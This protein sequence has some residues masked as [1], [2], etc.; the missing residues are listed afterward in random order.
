MHIRMQQWLSSN[1]A[2]LFL[3]KNT[4]K[5]KFYVKIIKKLLKLCL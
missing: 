4:L 5:W 1:I 3:M 2:F